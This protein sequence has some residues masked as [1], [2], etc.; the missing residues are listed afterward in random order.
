MVADP[1]DL[2]AEIEANEDGSIVIADVTADG[3][4]QAAGLQQG[5][6]LLAI[7]GLTAT[8]ATPLGVMLYLETRPPRS[9]LTLRTRR[10]GQDSNVS[11][12]LGGPRPSKF[13]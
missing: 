2:G 1:G 10:D 8:A 11:V 9:T 7:D 13:L 3:P 12:T 6:E 4:A 5:D